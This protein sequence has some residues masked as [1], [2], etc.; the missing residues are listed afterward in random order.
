MIYR[1]SH[2]DG[3]LEQS[4]SKH[5]EFPHLRGPVSPNRVSR[6]GSRRTSSH[7]RAAH[8]DYFEERVSGATA[9]KNAGRDS[10]RKHIEFPT[11]SRLCFP[12]ARFRVS[13]RE[14]PCAH[15][16]AAHEEYFEKQGLSKQPR[17]SP[18]GTIVQNTY[19]VSTCPRPLFSRGSFSRLGSR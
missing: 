4:S 18:A 15:R 3:R 16:H 13:A 6:L 2:E 17:R 7:H 12:E 8:E 5:I 11:R 14:E 9:T 10:S 1:N 19:R